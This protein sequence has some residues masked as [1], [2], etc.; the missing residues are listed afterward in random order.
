MRFYRP[1]A[2][3]PVEP[4][5]RRS[6]FS[7]PAAVAT[8]DSARY[9]LLYL[10]GTFNACFAETLVRENFD[11]TLTNR[12]ITRDDIAKYRAA[13]IEITA[14]L[15]LVDF[16]GVALTAAAVP[17]D[18][19]RAADHTAGRTWSAAVHEHPDH[20]DGILYHSRFTNDE[21]IAVY[22]RAVSKLGLVRDHRLD[23]H[24]DELSAALLLFN[25][26]LVDI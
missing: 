26:E 12:F 7:D 5:R 18:V 19:A 23:A 10:G 1:H 22:D 13:V 4:S 14:P 15:H 6:R 16:R 17:T 25:L 21:N 9:G 24:A 2:R 8:P 3:G 11:G 20:V